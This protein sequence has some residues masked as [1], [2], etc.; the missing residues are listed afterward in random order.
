MAVAGGWD[1]GVGVGVGVDE[2]M[3]ML[4]VPPATA[5]WNAA[6]VKLPTSVRLPRSA[7]ALPSASV[8]AFGPVAV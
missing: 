6:P 2:A 7:P 3:V 8:P 5:T 1:D 4:L